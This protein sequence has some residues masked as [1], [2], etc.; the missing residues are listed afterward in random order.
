MINIQ[1]IILRPAQSLCKCMMNALNS[2]HSHSPPQKKMVIPEHLKSQFF[3]TWLVQDGTEEMDDEGDGEQ[4]GED[5]T[6]GLTDFH[7]KQAQ[8]PW[9]NQD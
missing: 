1:W 5:V 4:E 7:A 6:N 3:H 9:Q 8:H 2:N